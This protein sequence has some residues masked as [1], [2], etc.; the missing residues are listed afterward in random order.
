[1]MMN[2]IYGIGDFTMINENRFC[3]NCWDWIRYD[4]NFGYCTKYKCQAR[5]DES[6]K[7]IREMSGGC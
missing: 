2:Y 3:R 1:M 4:D 6:C 7:I 5:H